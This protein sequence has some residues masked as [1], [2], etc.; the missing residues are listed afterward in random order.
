MRGTEIGKKDIQLQH[1]L[2]HRHRARFS[3]DT[4]PQFREAFTSTNWLVRVYQVLPSAAE[5]DEA[6]ADVQ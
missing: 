3:A 6:T 2:L 1:V 5:S 4:V